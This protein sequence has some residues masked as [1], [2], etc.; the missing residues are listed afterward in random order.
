M[1]P[2]KGQFKYCT[3][4]SVADVSRAVLST[5]FSHH[6][7]M[8]LVACHTSF[9]SWRQDVGENDGRKRDTHRY[10]A[11]AG[12]DGEGDGDGG[13]AGDGGG[14]SDGGDVVMVMAVM[15]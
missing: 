11:R 13:G 14:E 5:D 7:R 4:A 15:W 1:D 10:C 9:P 3:A 12:T 8:L 2:N 6:T